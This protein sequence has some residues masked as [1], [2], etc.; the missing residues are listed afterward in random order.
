[1]GKEFKSRLGGIEF[2]FLPTDFFKEPF[3]LAILTLLLE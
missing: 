2:L 3:F 1:M